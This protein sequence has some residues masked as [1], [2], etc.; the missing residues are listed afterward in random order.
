MDLLMASYTPTFSTMHVMH[1]LI[2]ITTLDECIKVT[3]FSFSAFFSSVSP[4]L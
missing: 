2:L 4:P 3:I 1:T